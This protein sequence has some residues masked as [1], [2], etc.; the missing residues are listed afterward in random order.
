MQMLRKGL[1]AF[2]LLMSIFSTNQALARDSLQLAA[3]RLTDSRNIQ[4]SSPAQ[5]PRPWG[6]IFDGQ[7][8][9]VSGEQYGNYIA[10]IRASDNTV[11]G[12]YPTGVSPQHAVYDGQ[13]IWVTN[14]IE[15]SVTRLHAV[16]GSLVG[17]YPVGAGPTRICYDGNF[18]WVANHVENSLSK[19]NAVTGG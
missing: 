5:I 19:L 15:N 14:S 8:V 12:V 10:K 9:W 11:L 18:M 1:K 7:N 3:G 6:V 17:T 2:L 13:D 16:D 4:I